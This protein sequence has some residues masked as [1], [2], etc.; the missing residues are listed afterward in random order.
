MASIKVNLNSPVPY[1]KPNET[2]RGSHPP[3]QRLQVQLRIASEPGQSRLIKALSNEFINYMA[4]EKN[5][6]PFSVAWISSNSAASFDHLASRSTDVAITHHVAAEGIAIKQGVVEKSVP[7]WRDHWLLVG[8]KSDPADLSSNKS[9]SV[10]DQFAQIFL[11]AA[12]TAGSAKPVRFLSRFD[13]SAANVR[14]SSLWAAIGQVPWAH[15]HAS[16]YHQYQDSPLGALEAASTLSQY[17]LTE[18]GTWFALNDAARDKLEIFSGGVGTE[19]E[20]LLNPAHALV[21]R[22]AQN[23]EMAN[24]FIAWLISHSGGQR[25]IREAEA[26]IERGQPKSSMARF[27]APITPPAT[28]PQLKW[29]ESQPHKG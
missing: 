26:G 20:L 27:A 25:V 19:D 29:K 3:R 1:V 2:Y 13:K 18:R 9:A 4:D 7:A 21:G 23:K 10:Q 24:E 11:A 15:P 8:P 22:H 12:E 28:P 14:E 6:E 16:W 17:T 5:S